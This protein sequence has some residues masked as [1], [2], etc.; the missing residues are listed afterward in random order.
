MFDGINVTHGNEVTGVDRQH[1][2]LR[3]D[4]TAEPEAFFKAYRP[5]LLGSWVAGGWGMG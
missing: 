1:S 2:T 4:W 3:H 5:S